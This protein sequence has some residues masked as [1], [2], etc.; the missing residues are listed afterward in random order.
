MIGAIK[1]VTGTKDFLP[2]SFSPQGFNF[3]AGAAYNFII[4]VACLALFVLGSGRISVDY[5]LFGRKKRI[6]TTAVPPPASPASSPAVSR[7]QTV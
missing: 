1:M 2:I 6:L 7:E 3:E 4:I 5:L